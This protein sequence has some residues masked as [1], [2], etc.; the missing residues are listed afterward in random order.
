MISQRAAAYCRLSKE[1]G[2]DEISQSIENQKQLLEEFAK[3]NNII[4][5]KFYIDDGYSGAKMSRPA[6]DQLKDDLNSDKV[7][8]VLAK[9]LSRIGRNSP[10][11]QLFLEN[12]IEQEKRV[13]APG[14]N[15]D[16]LNEQAQEMVGIQTWVDEKYVRDVSRKV[17]GAIDTM[18]RNGKYISCVPYGYYIDPFKKGVYYVDETCAIYVKEMFDM[19]LN[20]FGV[21][22]I[23]KEFTI[24]NIPT[25]SMIT[26]QR[27]ERLGKPYKGTASNRWYPNVIMDM[28]KNDFYIGTLT[29]GKTKRRSIH[30]KKIKQPEE[31]QYV[32]ENAHEP[33]VDKETFQLVQNTIANRGVTNFRGR[34]IQTRPNIF[35]GVLYCAKCGNRLT[36]AG[37]NKNTRYV[38]SLY[39]TH[40]TDFCSS[41]SITERDLK[42]ALI[43]FLE[44]CK[45]NLSEAINDLDNIIHKDS[46]KSEDNI[47][48]VL[49]KDI[50]RVEYEVKILLEQ[51]M[52]E[53]MK[54]PSM[55]SM[56][57]EM[58]EKM[59]EEKYDGL[60]SLKTQLEDK[61][62]N[63][64]DDNSIYKNLTSAMDIMTKIIETK[65][66]TKRQIAT[67]VD[68]IVVHE[69]G[70][71]DIYLKGNLHELCT[72]YVQY[73]MT[74]KEKILAATLDYIKTTPD[75]IIPTAA[76]KYS[77]AQGCRVGYPN[78][79]RIFSVLIKTGYVVKNEGYNK[80]YR[81]NRPFKTLYDDFKNNNIDYDASLCKNNNV[82]LENIKDICKWVQS[83][84]YKKK[85][86]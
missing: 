11:V 22:A 66:I 4:I 13:I 1:D 8:L 58:Y 57:D 43:Y 41:H 16:S 3:K 48:E 82:T 60:K 23:A 71:L 47:I 10:K 84:Q 44:H 68:K 28:L 36:S 64:F 25:G 73:K 39:N 18:Q 56:I 63:M 34:R 52:R 79:F 77:R 62:S 69:D 45:E 81:L 65:D 78:Y 72:N 83:L 49:E 21:R 9:D 6:F 31:K 51:K 24:R 46:Q 59:L 14:N 19:Y 32:F 17:R 80:G 12:I 54:N 5:D 55:I 50:A 7:D 37:K 76:W 20:G 27:L 61:K 29:L 85:L 35:V 15:Y 2:D 70:G 67:I 26:K 38:C 42:E 53:T 74:D 40:G 30:G 86:F 33:I 75:Y